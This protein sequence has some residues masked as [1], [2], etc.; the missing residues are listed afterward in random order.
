D[1]HVEDD[2]GRF[3]R[4]QRVDRPLADLDVC[5]HRVAT[6]REMKRIARKI[7]SGQPTIFQGLRKSCPLKR[8]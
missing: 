7:A 1:V 8:N 4:A 2:K 3:S 5:R 6:E